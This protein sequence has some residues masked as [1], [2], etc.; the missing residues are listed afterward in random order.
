MNTFLNAECKIAGYNKQDDIINKFIS[1]LK[2]KNFIVINSVKAT[3]NEDIYNKYDY[4][5][6]F[7]KST[8]FLNKTELRVDVKLAKY[9]TI[10]DQCGN[11]T[12]KN[13]KSDITVMNIPDNINQKNEISNTWVMFKTND[14]KELLNEVEPAK[15]LSKNDG[16]SYYFNILHYINKVVPFSNCIKQFKF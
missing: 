11:N 9:F 6:Y 10:I 5:V 4:I 8:P 12:I 3:L 2:I 1:Y 14:F 7:D 15:Y 13:S 16:K